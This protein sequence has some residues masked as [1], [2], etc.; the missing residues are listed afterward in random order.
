MAT[1]DTDT[2]TT[3]DPI[4]SMDDVTSGYGNTTVLHDVSIAIEEEDVACLIGPNGSGKSTLMKS[5][6]GFAD[7]QS[8]TVTFRDEDITG[9]SPQENLRNRISYVLQDA[10][11]FPNMTVQENMLMGGYVFD[12]DEQAA[13]RAETLYDEFPVLGDIRQQ[14]AGTLSGGQRRL[15]ELARALMVDPDLM[16]LDEPSIGLEPRFIDD[17]FERIEQLNDLGT[18]ILLV[19]QNAEKGLSVADRGFVLASGEI[20]FTGTGTEL[21]NNEEVG[22]L[23]LGG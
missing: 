21:L 6:Y 16:L 20:K 2:T 23:Y 10:S 15:L 4:L 8:G 13:E 14:K 9:R 22:R 1:S 3:T 19:E 12:D 11:V 5:I 17:V 18:T 7:V